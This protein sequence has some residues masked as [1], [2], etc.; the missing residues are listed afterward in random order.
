MRNWKHVRNAVVVAVVLAGW[1][2]VDARADM[3]ITEWM[4][5]GDGGEF[6][7]F[8]NI[9]ASAIDMTGWSYDDDSRK[10]GELNLSAF[11]SVAPGESVI[12]TET[13][14]NTFRDDWSLPTSVQ[15]IGGYSNNIGRSDEINLFDS[16]GNLIDRLTY[17]DQVF[18]GTIRTSGTS[19]TPNSLA[20]LGANDVT[21]WSFSSVGDSFGSYASTRGD[22]GNPGTAIPEP[23]TMALL[24]LGG[25]CTLIRRRQAQR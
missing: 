7:E 9:G 18:S 22:V 11:G 17:G 2:A 23:A 19:G 5:K 14:A 1:A 20:A 16:Q 13:S 10:V 4:Y 24:G 25:L 6:I 21:Q 15:I 3:R 12:I 8:T